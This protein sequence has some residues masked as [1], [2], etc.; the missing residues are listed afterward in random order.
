MDTA[1]NDV[2]G[3]SQASVQGYAIPIDTAL[4]IARQIAAGHASSVITIGYPSFLG[5]LVGNSSS[6]SP[7]V[8]AEQ[9]QA[10]SGFGGFGGPGASCYTSDTDVAVPSAVAPAA[11]GTLVDG[12]ICG[13]P[14]A[15][16]GLTAGSVIT[17]L[18]G[19]AIGAP[20]SLSSVLDGY[21]PGA[22]VSVTWVSLSG[23]RTTSTVTLAAGPPQ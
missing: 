14:A 19:H 11:S 20:A 2:T 13:S 21:R 7:Q 8:Q 6:S 22:T 23:R 9:Q 5:V 17:A 1:G 4:S 16:A 12:T 3:A 18:G 10:Q 15:N